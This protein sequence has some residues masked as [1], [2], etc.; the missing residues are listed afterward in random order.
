MHAFFQDL[1][2]GVRLLRRAPGFSAVAIATLAIS[3]GANTSIF[4][5]VNTLLL[6]ELP[7]RD[8]ARLAVVWEHN[9]PR[10]RKNNVV[11]PGNFIHWREMNHS[12]EDMA[13]VGLTFNMTLT[14]AGE[15][16]E[17][18]F[19]YVSASFFPVLGVA[20]AL[21]RPF[22]ADEDR[23]NARVVVVSDRLWKRR[24]KGDPR[25]LSRALTLEG[26]AYTIVGVM[27]PGFSFMDSTVDLWAPIGFEAAARAPRGRWLM[28]VGRL[29]PGVTL[30]RAQQDMTR[31]HAELTRLFP[32]FNT[33]WRARVVPLHEELSGD[34][35]PALLILLGAVAFVLLIASANVANLLLARATSRQRELAVRAALGAARGRL[36]RQLLAESAVLSAAGGLAGLL[37]AWGAVH[38]LR[39]VVAQSVPIQRL[40][41]VRLDGWVLAFTGAVSVCSGLFAGLVPA[42]AA[43]AGAL[44]D[45][46]RQ[47]GRSGSARSG[48]RSAFV[49]VE[50]SAAVV[51]LVGAGLLVRSFVTL[52]NID[53]GFDAAHTVT[54]RVSLPDTR[55][56]DATRAQ[57]FDR[58]FNAL[59]ALP[60]VE[61]TGATSFLP[62]SGPAAATSFTVV[63]QPAP[64]RGEEPV[65]DV[66]VVANHYFA[67]MGI[68]LLR[69]RLF[70][71][72]L[73]G[74]TTSRIIVNDALAR[75]YWPGE[76][77]I[78]KRIKVSW[79]NPR[80]DEIIG[81]VGDVRQASLD[82]QARPTN[83]WP[84][85][86]FAYRTMTIALR[87]KG[88][89][90][91]LIGAAKALIRSQDPEL[92]VANV[93][94]LEEVVAASVARQRLT[95]LLLSLFAASALVLAAVG[96][97]GVIA[98]SVTERTREIGIRMALGATAGDVMRMV[99]GQA[100]LL[101]S[102]GMVVGGALAFGLTRAMVNLLY[103]T[104]PADP[105]TYV[106][107]AAVLGAAAGLASYTP[108]RRATRVDPAIALRAQ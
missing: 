69:G 78:G 5:V 23:P 67:A 50:V 36:L 97:Y 27:P 76:D 80:E 17:V 94:T 65:T 46:L 89:P 66:R 4:S 43:S 103:G 47:A 62:L 10:D 64:R 49:I 61:A 42:M 82:T 34:V 25:V 35:R 58:L 96:I 102:I 16:E 37:L 92:A 93:R 26:E 24:L 99:M 100:L 75:K 71:E 108:G 91:P 45:A 30:E 20:P 21:G 18:P 73:P 70:D 22:T 104:R 88:N 98:Y 77:P 95:M 72:H 85:R 7:Y 44:T 13:A 107:V 9:V 53:P 68:P 28:V 59:D 101:T 3:I 14:G 60:G 56:S 11:S 40:D 6:Q 79:N 33:G 106:S 31:V 1:R 2:H 32:E 39:V 12:F 52:L 55:Y 54:L 81:V 83:Y 74:D 57:F 84:Y 51:L 19:Q 29:R 90:A 105:V 41:V 38:V 15:P 8:S 86:R 87:A 63:G 48:A